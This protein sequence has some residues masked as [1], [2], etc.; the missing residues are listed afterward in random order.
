MISTVNRLALLLACGCVA[1]SG[2]PQGG[3]WVVTAKDDLNI[4]R[5]SETIVLDAQEFRKANP[6]VDLKT[7]HVKDAASGMEMLTQTVDLNGDAVW[8]QLL[9]QADLGPGETRRFRLAIGER[10]IPLK[11][12]Y[13]AYGR[14]VR[15]RFDD[16]AWEN[17]RAAFRT[18][19]TALETWQQEPLTSSAIDVWCKRVRRLVINDWYMVDDYHRDTGEGG[20]LY[21]AGRSRGCG[22]SGIWEEGKLHVSRNFIMSKVIANGPIRVVFELAY[23][24]W[25]ITGW[26]VSEVK[27]ITLDAGQNLNRIE[28]VYQSDR[29]GEIRFAAGIKKA[30]GS[31]SLA[32]KEAAWLR[33]WEA[34]KGNGHL[35]CGIVIDPEHLAD[36][37]EG[38]GNCLVVAKATIGQAA[39]YY[40]GF[41]W[42]KSA[43]FSSVAD[44]EAYLD[45]YAKRLRSPVKVSILGLA[46]K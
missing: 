42:D 15:E 9:F 44:W 13:K 10:Q 29:R 22:G 24:P 14:F 37:T 31:T 45:Q 1:W 35:G 39:V 8:D 18:Y 36:I 4:A 26:K 21:S 17:D 20:D 32:R 28:S 38:E 41:G 34:L 46:Q 7:I 3:G 40:A 2:W 30:D 12:Q 16:F 33:T 11:D 6:K 23:A 43:D 5:P 25:E 27:R 19:G